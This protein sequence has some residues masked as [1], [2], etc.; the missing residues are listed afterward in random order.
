MPEQ[1]QERTATTNTPAAVIEECSEYS[2]QIQNWAKFVFTWKIPF[3]QR[4]FHLLSLAGFRRI[5]SDSFL[6]NSFLSQEQPQTKWK[7]SIRKLNIDDEDYLQVR[8]HAEELAAEA[9]VVQV[10]I[11][12]KLGVKELGRRWNL[13]EPPDAFKISFAELE[14]DPAYLPN[15]TLTMQF[16]IETLNLTFTG[17]ESV[18]INLIV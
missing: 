1:L 14:S 18:A 7:L 10:S 5:F 4:Q 12:N 15:G 6:S 8:L 2:T 9:T 11:T 13:W 16:A 17:Y 3:V